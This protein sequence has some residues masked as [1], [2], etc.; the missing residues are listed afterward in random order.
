MAHER[1]T[2]YVAMLPNTCEDDPTALRPDRPYEIH[3][4]LPIRASIL[5]LSSGGKDIND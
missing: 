2:P 5:K 4:D 1:T 3:V